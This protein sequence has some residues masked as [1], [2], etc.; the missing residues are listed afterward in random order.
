MPELPEHLDDLLR[1]CAI[2][3]A[4]DAETLGALTGATTADIQMLLDRGDL[5]TQPG[6]PA[7]YTSAGAGRQA[8][9]MRLRL[10]RPRDEIDL[11]AHAFHHYLLRLQSHGAGGSRS[12]D[13]EE[14]LYHLG[15]LHDL[16]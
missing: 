4:F 16:F 2:L 9:L 13:E 7:R 1:W 5:A 3:R 12:V 6:A 10:E 15:A 11:H 8:A 14:S